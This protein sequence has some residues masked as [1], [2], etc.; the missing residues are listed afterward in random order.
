M[1]PIDIQI[2]GWVGPHIHVRRAWRGGHLSVWESEA[3][4]ARRGGHLSVWV[5]RAWRG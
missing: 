1:Y 3:T 4:S 2:T 5:R